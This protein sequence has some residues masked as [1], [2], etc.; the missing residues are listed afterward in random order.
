MTLKK[1]AMVAVSLAGVVLLL[2]IG[3]SKV[4][5]SDGQAPA[6]LIPQ[7]DHNPDLLTTY[8]AYMN[9]KAQ[10]PSEETEL[11]LS[12]AREAARKLYHG[13]RLGASIDLMRASLIL[14]SSTDPK[15]LA[16][17][18]DLAVEALSRGVLPA[19]R[20]VLELQDRLLLSSGRP[21]RYGTQKTWMG[22]RLPDGPF[23][24][25]SERT[26]K[27]PNALRTS[28]ANPVTAGE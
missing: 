3:S 20:I 25:S 1:D 17:S 27:E 28:G 12:S 11:R 13:G 14:S 15:D 24:A 6:T 23:P 8:I 7:V 18:H 10:A 5:G 4:G 16:L 2:A 22:K 21:Q 19:R 9:I 26:P